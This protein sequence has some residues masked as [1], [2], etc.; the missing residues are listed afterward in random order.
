MN[1]CGGCLLAVHMRLPE[2][3]ISEFSLAKSVELSPDFAEAWGLLAGGP[4]TTGKDGKIK[5]KKPLN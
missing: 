4:S 2:S 5:L 1:P 3:G